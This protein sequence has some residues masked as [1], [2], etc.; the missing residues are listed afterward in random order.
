LTAAPG[1]PCGWVLSYVEALTS[2]EHLSV[3][4]VFRLPVGAGLAL[5]EAR[6]VRLAAE[7]GAEPPSGGWTDRA[8]AAARRRREEQLRDTHTIISTPQQHG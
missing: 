2:A 4:A 5:L 3:G 7:A 6:R 1:P 8:T